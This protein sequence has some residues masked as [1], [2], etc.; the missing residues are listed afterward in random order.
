[1]VKTIDI[2]DSLVDNLQISDDT[3]KK[4]QD[5]Y[6]N[7]GNWLNR[8]NSTIKIYS[9]E[10]YSQGS[11]RLGTA[12]KPIDPDD[13]YDI[14]AVCVLSKYAYKSSYTQKKI[15]E[16]VGKEVKSYVNANNFNK[17]A[18][19][20]KRCWTIEYADSEQFHM[21]ILPSI[22]D[23]YGL[24][25]MF[26]SYG[27]KDYNKDYTKH[28]ISIT[29]NTHHNYAH[30]NQDWP[31]SNPMG[32]YHWF[33]E[34][35]ITNE[36]KSLDIRLYE[37]VEEIPNNQDSS[38][39][40][41]VVMLLK[42]HRDIM[43]KDSSESEYKPI[44]I[45]ITTLA[46]QAYQGEDN[47]Q[48]A[49]VSVISNMDVYNQ[50]GIYHIPNPVNPL[51]NFADK[52]QNERKLIDNFFKWFYK[53]KRDFESI[54]NGDVYNSKATFKSMFGEQIINESYDL[55][56]IEDQNISD[57]NNVLI[58]MPHVQKPKW[59]KYIEGN[60]TISC[61]V[62]SNGFLTK[63]ISSNSPLYKNSK[64]IFTTKVSKKLRK[65][66]IE[67]HWQVA[68]SGTE[69]T[70]A[71]QLRGDFYTGEIEKGGKVRTETTS[72]T[73]IHFVKSFA[74]ENGVIIAESTP[75]LVNIIDRS[76]T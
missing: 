27:V 62:I 26:E 66:K 60:I 47:L 3:Y 73:G 46:A 53:L 36:K 71:N 31:N 57:L 25:A 4:A 63:T 2:L 58:S 8:D 23:E 9:P 15:K 67:Y 18:Q 69:A 20:A 75:F 34:R 24:I 61:K 1:M 35:C 12:I 70:S 6:T 5:R 30:I 28:A 43:Y 21:D 49:L 65:R 42:R 37:G 51:E 10:I 40:Q 13:D 55:N 16:L 74:V 59:Q 19:E 29:D 48:D 41:Y 11:I 45:I 72:Y 76:L 33:K 56:G 44:S 54:L 17:E 39:L 68:N 38:P 52:W 22:P 14:D 7:L 32:Y 64:L 50:D